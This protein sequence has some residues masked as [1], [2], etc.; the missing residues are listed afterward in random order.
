MWL[1]PHRAFIISLDVAG[2]KTAMY[3][4]MQGAKE[5]ERVP[6]NY[7]AGQV[8][9]TFRFKNGSTYELMSFGDFV[10]FLIDVSDR[11]RLVEAVE[12]LSRSMSFIRN[13]TECCDMWILLNKQDLVPDA[14]REQYVGKAR[15]YLA[16]VDA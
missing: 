12:E 6:L 10:I 5:V 8:I 14:L 11:D 3:R 9:E 13:E 16:S 15:R 1:V 7:L 2:K 4:F